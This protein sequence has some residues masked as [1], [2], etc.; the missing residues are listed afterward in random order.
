[1]KKIIF[2][3]MACLSFSSFAADFNFIH[4][5]FGTDGA[6]LEPVPTKS[7]VQQAKELY[8]AMKVKAVKGKKF[9][10]I[11]VGSDLFG[12]TCEK[13]RKG[14]HTETALCEFTALSSKEDSDEGI[15]WQASVTVRKALAAELMNKIKMKR[16]IRVGAT[17]FG[18]AN[19]QCRTMMSNRG[20]QQVCTLNDVNSTAMDL[21][22]L[23]KEGAMTKAQSEKLVKTIGY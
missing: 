9:V 8:N 5:G 11:K 15:R 1:M 14:I 20:L 17:T 22:Y 13:P 2:L 10:G 16:T 19:L 18:V 21:D 6:S 3:A 4:A 23:V 7:S 12:L